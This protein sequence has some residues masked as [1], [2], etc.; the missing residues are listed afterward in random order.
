M[1]GLVLRALA[2]HLSDGDE[3][4]DANGDQCEAA[5]GDQV[6]R[7]ALEGLHALAIILKRPDWLRV[8]EPDLLTIER[9]VN[10]D[11]QGP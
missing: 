9:Q 4:D 5:C 10:G 1:H 3:S 11:E 7:L 6:E 2:S 8:S